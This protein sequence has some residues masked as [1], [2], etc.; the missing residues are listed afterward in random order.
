MD[1]SGLKAAENEV[2]ALKEAQSSLE[3]NAYGLLSPLRR[4]LRKFVK[5]TPSEG[6]D[7]AVVS[8]AKKI[9]EDPVAAYFDGDVDVQG[10]LKALELYCG[11]KESG[12]SA[13]ERKKFMERIGV[14]GKLRPKEDREKRKALVER[15]RQLKDATENDLSIVKRKQLFK[16]A[17]SQAEIVRE[18]AKKEENI[19]HLLS[20]AEDKSVRKKDE[21]SVLKAKLASGG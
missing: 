9:E 3:L 20:Q 10:V 21:I 7:F 18:L 15:L 17:E 19:K 8:V 16:E 4:L 5:W 14:A 13:S 12:L 11:L 1:D 2:A 6:V